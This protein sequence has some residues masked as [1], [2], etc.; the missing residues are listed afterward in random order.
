MLQLAQRPLHGIAIQPG[1]FR[2][3]AHRRER[4]S[5]LEPA[6]H[7]CYDELFFELR[8]YRPAVI[9]LP[10]QSST[11]LLDLSS[12]RSLS[13]DPG[14]CFGFSFGYDNLILV[15]VLIFTS[16]L[17]SDSLLFA[18]C[19]DAAKACRSPKARAFASL[20]LLSYCPMCLGQ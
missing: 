8:P 12:L 16:Y 11:L 7:Y 14:F 17:A 3:L 9:K 18:L 4:S 13:S 20:V 6:G 10:F 1:V 15:L 2:Q 19:T 5:H